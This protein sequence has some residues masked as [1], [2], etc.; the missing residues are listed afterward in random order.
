L[1]LKKTPG[2]A[3]SSMAAARTPGS[4][5]PR[6]PAAAANCGGQLC[7][8]PPPLPAHTPVS[9]EQPPGRGG[10]ASPWRAGKW[11]NCGPR[12][13]PGNVVPGR[14]EPR[15]PVGLRLSEA[16]PKP[17]PFLATPSPDGSAGFLFGSA[18]SRCPSGRAAA[19]SLHAEVRER[20]SLLHI[21]TRKLS[22]QVPAL[23]PLSLGLPG[24]FVKK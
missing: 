2:P 18:A 6:R 24:R 15:L 5:L 21:R 17:R 3:C 10:R 7:L 9:R 22:R 14:G 20:R 4:S 23:A 13:L 11:V 1:L 8:L 12:G 19:G 16:G